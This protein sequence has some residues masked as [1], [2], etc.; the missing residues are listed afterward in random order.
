MD[1]AKAPVGWV[2]TPNLERKKRNAATLATPKK[3]TI[4]LIRFK[5]DSRKEHIM[6][7]REFT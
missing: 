3:L 2:G 5:N 4:S 1:F 6:F 7:K